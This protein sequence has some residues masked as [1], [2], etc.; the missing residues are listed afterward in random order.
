[1]VAISLCVHNNDISTF[2]S[3]GIENSKGCMAPVLP[4]KSRRGSSLPSISTSF[5][6][7]SGFANT[8]LKVYTF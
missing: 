6:L 7:H 1:M 5:H 3:H 8:C 4:G 2:L